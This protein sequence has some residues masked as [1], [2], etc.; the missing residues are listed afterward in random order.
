MTPLPDVNNTPPLRER[1]C[2][3]CRDPLQDDEQVICRSCTPEMECSVCGELFSKDD[4]NSYEYE[5][6]WHDYCLWC[7]P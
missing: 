1:P 5:G 3:I 7:D 4:V 2:G 6:V